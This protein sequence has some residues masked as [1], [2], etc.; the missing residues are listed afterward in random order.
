MLRYHSFIFKVSYD[1]VELDLPFFN[2]DKPKEHTLL[3]VV[4]EDDIKQ[5]DAVS[6]A[7]YKAC[8]E[9]KKRLREQQM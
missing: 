9:Y 6:E 4:N 2:T 8:E 3:V 5:G 1:V 7:F